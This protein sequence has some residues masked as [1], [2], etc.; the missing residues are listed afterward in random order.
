M[1]ESVLHFL[2][3]RFGDGAWVGGVDEVPTDDEVISTR[4][5]RLD[6]R[7]GPLLV[8]NALP[9]LSNARRNDEHALADLIAERTHLAAGGDH[10]VASILSRLLRTAQ[11]FVFNGV[12]VSQLFMVLGVNARQNRNHKDLERTSSPAFDGC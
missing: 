2:D 3:D 10:P 8:V 4:L 5:N 9:F 6:G 12:L 1:V 7:D 11:N